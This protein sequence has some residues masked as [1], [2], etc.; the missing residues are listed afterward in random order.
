VR[1]F[2]ALRGFSEGTFELAMAGTAM[3]NGA[4]VALPVHFRGERE[5]AEMAMDGVDLL[6]IDGTQIAQVWLFSAA[7]KTEDAFWGAG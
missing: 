2:A 3:A 1:V 7:P 5:D 6:R 4:L